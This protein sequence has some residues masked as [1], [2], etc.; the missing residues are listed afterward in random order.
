[1]SEANPIRG[2][3]A[4]RLGTETIVLKPTFD[5]MVRLEQRL[6]A[7]IPMLLGRLAHR[8]FGAREA[9]ALLSIAGGVKPARVARLVETH[10]MTEIAEAAAVFLGNC[11]RGG[12]RVEDQ[13]K[14]RDAPDESGPTTA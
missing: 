8:G 1:M 2:E 13:E 3:V 12:A 11:L 9:E 6:D 4:L 10:G 7:P 5:A 14:N